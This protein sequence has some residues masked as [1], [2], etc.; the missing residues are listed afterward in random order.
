MT[1]TF[2][3]RDEDLI[4]SLLLADALLTMTCLPR[5]VVDPTTRLRLEGGQTMEICRHRG[6]AVSLLTTIS[7]LR[8]GASIAHHPLGIVAL[9]MKICLPLGGGSIVRTSRPH[10]DP[11][12]QEAMQSE[13]DRMMI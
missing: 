10:E 11:Q 12:A 7:P 6:E 5:G 8:E 9:H 1:R 3:R 4:V 13:A 2:R